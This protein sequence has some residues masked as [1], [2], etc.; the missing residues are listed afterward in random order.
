MTLSPL[1][2]WLPGGPSNQ[3]RTDWILHLNGHEPRG[4]V[5]FLTE[6]F[7]VTDSTDE[8]RIDA[9]ERSARSPATTTL[10]DHS[11][12]QYHQQYYA[13]DQLGDQQSHSASIITL[14]ILTNPTLRKINPTTGRP[15]GRQY[16]TTQSQPPP[17]IS[18]E[19]TF[20]GVQENCGTA[21]KAS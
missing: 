15:A 3:K 1:A 14:L 10:S 6:R 2:S 13:S 4:P 11:T 9:S 7:G 5:R 12:H 18:N 20:C 8:R 16:I 21:S 19:I 17:Q